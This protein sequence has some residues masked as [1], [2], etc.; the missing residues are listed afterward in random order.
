MGLIRFSLALAVLLGHCPKQLILP[1]PINANEAVQCF[2]AISGFYIHLVI[3]ET[4]SKQGD[5]WRRAFY[6]SRAARIFPL[7]YLFTIMFL[8]FLGDPSGGSIT[9]AFA[10][11]TLVGLSVVNAGRLLGFLLTGQPLGYPE[12]ID[13]AAWSLAHEACFYLIAP[14]ILNKSTWFVGGLAIVLVL[15]SI[16]L[17]EVHASNPSWASMMHLDESHYCQF[18]PFE[19]SLF[20]F[21]ALA[22]RLYSVLNS[23][24]P[25]PRRAAFEPW[26]PSSIAFHAVSGVISI[27]YLWY[28]WSGACWSVPNHIGHWKF[29][30]NYWLIL[31]NL[32][33]GLPFIFHFTCNIRWDRAVGEL[34]YPIYLVH[35]LVMKLVVQHIAPKPEE[36]YLPV[37][38]ISVLLSLLAWRLV[39]VP[40]AAWR[41]RRFAPK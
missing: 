21:G 7:Y 6:E 29:P 15:S 11:F 23:K 13:L 14:W 1:A 38:V 39:D 28:F 40:V 8:I 27:A 19:L 9:S 24:W 36:L 2:F 18:Y 33:I 5:G 3:S 26:K 41:H 22:Y 17:A 32:I 12:P 16:A 34:S 37:L 35:V 20:L 30:L 4:Y 10:N 31:I 25:L